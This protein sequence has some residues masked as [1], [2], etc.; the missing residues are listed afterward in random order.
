VKLTP[1]TGPTRNPTG[2]DMQTSVRRKQTKPP[3]YLFRYT[4]LS[5]SKRQNKQSAPNFLAQPA[6]LTSVCLPFLRRKRLPRRSVRRP[7]KRLSAAGEGVFTDSA[8]PP[9]PLFSAFVI[10]PSSPRFPTHEERA[11]VYLRRVA[12]LLRNFV[13]CAYCARAC[14]RRL[15]TDL[16]PGS[17]NRRADDATRPI[18]PRAFASRETG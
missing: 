4:I 11:A 14:T 1:V 16:P 5:K 10:F 12:A 2:V 13:S 7:D 17:R 8:Q 6:D 3:A 15:S 9:Q 18:R